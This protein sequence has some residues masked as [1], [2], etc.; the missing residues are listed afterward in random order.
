MPK[1]EDSGRLNSWEQEFNG[2]LVAIHVAKNVSTARDLRA[3]LV[4][5]A[6]ALP[7]MRA[8]RLLI[9]LFNGLLSR[10]RLEQEIT[11]FRSIVRPEIGQAI[12]AMLMTDLD[13]LQRLGLDGEEHAALRQYVQSALGR[14]PRFATKEAVVGMLLHRWI[15]RDEP[16]RISAIAA[17]A[18]ASLPTVYGALESIRPEC[19]MRANGTQIGISRFWLEDWVKWLDSAAGGPKARFV[20]R[21]GSPR[22]AEKLSRRLF[23]LGRKDLAVGGVLAARH[24]LPGLDIVSA[25]H[26]DILVHGDAHSDLSFVQQ[27]DPGL[28]RDDSAADRAHVVVHFINRPVSLFREEGDAVWGDILDCMANLWSAGMTD[29]VEEIIRSIAPDPDGVWRKGSQR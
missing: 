1:A 10:S 8:R 27:L 4:D 26:L 17:A 3:R 16:A 7:E 14:K 28:V 19:I 24:I 18:G 9:L 25:P 11:R 22:S 21:S 2:E 5:A 12:D 20:D 23:E 15:E 13:D 29:Q 6:Y